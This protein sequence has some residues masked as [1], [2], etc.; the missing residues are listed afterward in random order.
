MVKVKFL[1]IKLRT[2]NYYSGN[3]TTVP[4]AIKYVGWLGVFFFM[5]K[6]LILN[7]QLTIGTIDSKDMLDHL[8]GIVA[9]IFFVLVSIDIF[10]ITFVI[11][12][13]RKIRKD[14]ITKKS[15]RMK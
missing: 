15:W 5:V 9:V 3:A 10:L 13:L 12:N 2:I 11:G 6:Y 14:F 1:K 8:H 7:Y 4:E